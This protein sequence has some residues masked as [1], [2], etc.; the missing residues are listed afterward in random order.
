MKLNLLFIAM[1]LITILVYPI[2]FLYG[3]LCKLPKLKESTALA[4]LLVIDPVTAGKQ[5]IDRL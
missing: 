3:K 4:N 5:P 2:V 1:D